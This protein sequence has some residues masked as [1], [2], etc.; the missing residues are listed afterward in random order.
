MRRTSAFALRSSYTVAS[1]VSRRGGNALRV[2]DETQQIQDHDVFLE[3]EY[4]LND[5]E[6]QLLAAPIADFLSRCTSYD[7]L[8]T[9]T[10]VVVLDVD[11][12]LTV[13]F[14]AAQ[15]TRLNACVLWDPTARAFCGMLSS[16]D[17]ID[18]LLYCHD[19]PDEAEQ[20]ARY[21]IR[22]WREKK[23]DAS[24]IRNKQI[25]SSLSPTSAFV[26]CAPDTTLIKCLQLILRHHVRRIT[27]LA[28]KEANDVSVVAILD[29]Q[30][31]LLYLGAVF[32]SIEAVGNGR[33]G[34]G[35]AAGVDNVNSLVGVSGGV[36]AGISP[37]GVDPADTDLLFAEGVLPPHVRNLL[38]APNEG[39]GE[40]PLME[41]GKEPRV[42]PYRTIFDIPFCYVPQLGRHRAHAISVTLE[43]PLLEALRLMLQHDIESIAVVSEEYIIVDVINR[44]D[45]V[46]IED[47][48]VYDTELTVREAI[49][50]TVSAKI[51]VF[52]AKDALRDIFFHFA[53]QRVKEL[54][55]VDP[56]TDKLLG[57]LN[58]AE[59]VFF[60][61]F[62]VTTTSATGDVRG[63]V[64]TAFSSSPL[65][66]STPN[67]AR[68][69]AAANDNDGN[70]QK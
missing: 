15:E 17:Y 19:H 47:Q 13:A 24:D 66:A 42:G 40:N 2:N 43:S 25:L 7:M 3:A 56:D 26:T 30:Q 14:I 10:Q 32:L 54:F 50:S 39:E 51:C 65:L 69:V 28:N 11:V 52:H 35:V 22:E 36:N 38:F 12:A 8:G 23:R 16:T 18:I 57:Q 44:S 61:V 33:R 45:I 46:R 63:C 41:F 29:L 31:I 21:T 5:E 64:Q 68:A 70:A 53:R 1:G 59:M 4:Y 58:I 62:G 60:L 20:V 27:V 6:C 9:S 34:V 55:L 48:G 67:P 49:G 37:D